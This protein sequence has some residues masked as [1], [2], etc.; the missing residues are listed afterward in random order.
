MSEN[1]GEYWSRIAR[2]WALLGSPLRPSEPDLAAYRRGVAEFEQ[3]EAVVLGA[4]LE[5]A[6]LPW[7]RGSRVVAIDHNLDIIRA[8]WPSSGGPAIRADWQ[9]LPLA[10]GSQDLALCDG[11]L[12][13]TPF[14]NGCECIAANLSTVLRAGGLA[15][16]RAY[17]LPDRPELP[18]QVLDDLLAGRIPSLNHLKLRL[19]MALQPNSTDGVRLCRIWDALHEAA[20][21]LP[22]LAA[23][24]GWDLDHLEAID[25]YRDSPNRYYFSNLK[26]VRGPF[27]RAGF[28]LEWTSIP[29]YEM[30]SQCPVLCFRKG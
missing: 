25:A 3:P 14:P 6:A 30:G 27:E 20:P 19:G 11:G 5:F 7:P 24:I 13:M 12:S 29:S 26:D 2:H 23:R 28:R 18:E 22:A 10:S 16:I 15:L 8:I 1:T 21:S 4:T 17:L 9:A